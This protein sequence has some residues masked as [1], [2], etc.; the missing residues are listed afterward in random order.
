L[1]RVGYK[2][3]ALDCTGFRSGSLNDALD[4]ALVSAE[5]LLGR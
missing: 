1:K 4:S 5:T 2:Y 3:V